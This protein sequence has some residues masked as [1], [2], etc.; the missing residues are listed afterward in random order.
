M[1]RIWKNGNFEKLS[2]DN[3]IFPKKDTGSFLKSQAVFRKLPRALKKRPWEKKHWILNCW[4]F[5]NI[6][7]Y[8]PRQKKNPYISLW[9][10]RTRTQCFQN[11]PYPYPS[12][13]HNLTLNFFRTRTR[14]QF[15]KVIRTRLIYAPQNQNFPVLRTFYVY[16]PR[17]GCVDVDGIRLRT[18]DSA[19]LVGFHFAKIKPKKCGLRIWRKKIRTKKKTEKM[20]FETIKNFH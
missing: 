7:D 20:N 13:H 12:T 3:L 17:Y 10:F 4:I 14:T 8:L 5:H 2:N 6:I 18:P 19:V 15:S 9:K 16:V 1:L 11:N